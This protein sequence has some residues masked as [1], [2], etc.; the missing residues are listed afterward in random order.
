MSTVVGASVMTGIQIVL[1]VVV[2]ALLAAALTLLWIRRRRT[3][4]VLIADATPIAAS[5]PLVQH[6]GSRS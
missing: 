5:P 6:D 4:G 1:L 3:G 2:V